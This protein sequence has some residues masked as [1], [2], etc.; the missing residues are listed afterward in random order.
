MS[1]QEVPLIC[2]QRIIYAMIFGF[3]LALLQPYTPDVLNLRILA[4]IGADL[5][6]R[7][8]MMMVAPVVCVSMIC[9]VAN[10]GP[11]TH[12]GRMGLKTIGLYLITTLCGVCMALSFSSIV[13]LGQGQSAMVSAPINRL[14]KAL[15]F[16][17]IITQMVPMNPIEALA[18][19]SMLQIIVMASTDCLHLLV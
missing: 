5:F 9:G 1:S 6:M 15:D 14:S 3:I 18:T 2:A 13:Y 16:K 12:L 10:Q 4:D 8:I 7:L 19:A 11:V 17:A